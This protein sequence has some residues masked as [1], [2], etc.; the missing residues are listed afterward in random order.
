MDRSS[1][2]AITAE[3]SRG[4]A[5][6]GEVPNDYTVLMPVLPTG[7]EA[8]CSLVLH[9]DTRGRPYRV[10]DFVGPLN[11]V[12]VREDITGLGAYQMGHVWLVKLR[13]GEAKEKLLSAG[14]LKVKNRLCL[15]VDPVRRELRVKVHWVAFGVSVD[16]IRRAFEPY[17]EVKGVAREKWKIEGLVDVDSTT[18]TVRIVLRDSLTPLSLPHQFRINGGNVLVVVPG[19]APLCLRCRRT[20]HIRRDCKV[21][22]CEECRA[23]GHEARDCVRSYARA[24]AGQNLEDS[25]AT[26]LMDEVE[27]EAAATPSTRHAA[28]EE[29]PPTSEITMV[30]RSA[31][32]DQTTNPAPKLEG[33]TGNTQLSEKTPSPASPAIGGA[34]GASD[35]ED[36][37]A[38]DSEGASVKRRHCEVVS[39]NVESHQQSQEGESGWQTKKGRGAGRGRSSHSP[40]KTHGRKENPVV[41][42]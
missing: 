8:K 2:I 14:N 16:A 40:G 24:V 4:D 33:A 25:G 12:G 35:G 29:S 37:V 34:A 42:P 28:P 11:Q 17:G 1:A 39:G 3:A 31:P 41:V 20:G 38:M 36:A 26:Y 7:D 22:R 9:A 21:P 10:E 30:Q 6:H 32:Q 5:A 15:I 27:A 18:V 23:F 19:R 13:T